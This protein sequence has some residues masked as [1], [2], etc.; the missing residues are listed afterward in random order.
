MNIYSLVE[1]RTNQQ[2]HKIFSNKT[3]LGNLSLH[4]EAILNHA[5]KNCFVSCPFKPAQRLLVDAVFYI[6]RVRRL[7]STRFS[8]LCFSTIS[9]CPYL[10]I[11]ELTCSRTS[12]FKKIYCFVLLQSLRF[13]ERW[14]FLP[15]LRWFIVTLMTI[16]PGLE[17][18]PVTN[19]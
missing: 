2:N 16:L 18:S 9:T 12:S 1:F 5:I 3:N 13:Y 19:F 17:F 11:S 15:T 14:N 10:L 8:M 6:S 4:F 7:F